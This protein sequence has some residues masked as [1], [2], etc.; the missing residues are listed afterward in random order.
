MKCII[1]NFWD[2]RYIILS[3]IFSKEIVN[4]LIYSPYFN[5]GKSYL[6]PK[7]GY[8]K[9][10]MILWSWIYTL[11]AIISH[12]GDVQFIGSYEKELYLGISSFIEIHKS[13]YP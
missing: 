12:D 6:S 3:T 7:L 2:I 8:L 4:S 10:V 11:H 5:V 13:H 1:R 9:N